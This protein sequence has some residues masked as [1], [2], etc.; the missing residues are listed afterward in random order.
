MTGKLNQ[1][2]PK[3]TGHF[4]HMQ[5][6][7]VQRHLCKLDMLRCSECTCQDEW[8][9]G[10]SVPGPAATKCQQ[11]CAKSP[12]GQAVVEGDT[13]DTEHPPSTFPQ[14]LPKPPHPVRARFG[15]RVQET[16]RCHLSPTWS[17]DMRH[18]PSTLVSVLIAS[19]I[20]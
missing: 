11:I 12:E 16:L 19:F 1:M 2:I 20:A 10:Q 14:V 9:L 4:G 5:C 13:G 7:L 6:W 3:E 17:G 8:A 18:T 15:Y